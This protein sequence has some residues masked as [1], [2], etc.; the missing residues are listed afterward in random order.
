METKDKADVEDRNDSKL[1]WWNLESE[2]S[3]IGKSGY[4]RVDKLICRVVAKK[5]TS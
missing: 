1:G 5:G 2:A 3:N 4:I